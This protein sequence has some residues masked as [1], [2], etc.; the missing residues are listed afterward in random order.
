MTRVRVG[1][2]ERHAVEIHSQP[3]PRVLRRQPL[4]P[5]ELLRHA[6][7]DR[8]APGHPRLLPGHLAE[9]ELLARGQHPDERLADPLLHRLVE[10]LRLRLRVAALLRVEVELLPLVADERHAR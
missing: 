7:G 3:R 6:H 8:I 9:A 5:G 10:V 1:R 2:P 4:L